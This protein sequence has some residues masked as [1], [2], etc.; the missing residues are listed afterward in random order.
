MELLSRRRA[1]TL[2]GAAVMTAAALPVPAQAFSAEL[3]RISQYLSGQRTLEGKFVQI[4][5][6]GLISDG[7]F[8][9]MR[10]GRMR[11]EFTPP[12]PLR[13]IADGYW[14]IV[15]DLQLDSVDRYPLT[16]T[17]L[18]LILKDK[19]DLNGTDAVQ[20]IERDEGVVRVTAHDPNDPDKGNIIL[21]FQ[22]E[23][24]ALK[25]WVV[26]DAQGL[27][28]VV[29]LRDVRENGPVDP[30]LFHVSDFAN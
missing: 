17:P 2:T 6:D 8:Y 21:V 28:T 9:L 3:Q 27:R 4:A 20:N 10:P 23:P 11:F 25:Q 14:V 7:T 22:N 30:A 13:V 26:T 18:G 1:I 16:K 29:T 15:E 5:P 19:V 24:L 12:A